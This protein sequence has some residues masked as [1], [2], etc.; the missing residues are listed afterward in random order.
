MT[1]A[2]RQVRPRSLPPEALVRELYW[3]RWGPRA[4]DLGLDP[5]EVY[6]EV[7]VAILSPRRAPYDPT[8]G[9]LSTWLYC[10]MR[11][12]VH[13]RCDRRRR[14]NT[15]DCVYAHTHSKADP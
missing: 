6:Q 8:R 9:S 11:T 13:N 15:R 3:S 2:P 12:T 4:V 10:V 7:W 5:D 14:S 1:V